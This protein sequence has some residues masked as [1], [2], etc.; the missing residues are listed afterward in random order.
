MVS[1]AAHEGRWGPFPGGHS[2][3]VLGPGTSG[4][5]GVLPGKEHV[6]L[7]R[8]VL[9]ADIAA[10]GVRGAPSWLLTVGRRSTPR[11]CRQRRPRVVASVPHRRVVARRL[12]ESGAP[13]AGWSSGQCCTLA[14]KNNGQ[15][16]V[17]GGD[18][19]NESIL[20]FAP[21]HLVEKKT[22]QSSQSTKVACT[23][24][25]QNVPCP[26]Q[27]K[28]APSTPAAI[29]TGSHRAS[30]QPVLSK[31]RKPNHGAAQERPLT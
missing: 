23:L 20:Q 24:F 7:S 8:H 25:A 29:M 11:R 9:R 30:P 31:P 16:A 12:R 19:G 14:P 18:S 3:R 6:A 10:G 15:R 5:K 13:R 22:R 1:E 2:G 26:P 21:T 28:H 17:R 27:T 4:G